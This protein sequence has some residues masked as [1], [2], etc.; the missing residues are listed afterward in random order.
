MPVQNREL[1]PQDGDLHVLGIWSRAQPDQAHQPPQRHP[2]QRPHHHEPDHASP[3]IV[4]GH[5]PSRDVAPFRHPHLPTIC[6][7]C[8]GAG[9]AD[10]STNTH[11]HRSRN[12]DDVLGTHRAH[13][14]VPAGRL[15]ERGVAPSPP[16]S[17][18]PHLGKIAVTASSADTGS[19]AKAPPTPSENLATA[20]RATG[21]TTNA[22][23]GQRHPEPLEWHPSRPRV[24]RKR[25]GRS[26]LTCRTTTATAGQS[27]GRLVQGE[28]VVQPG[29]R[30][31]AHCRLSQGCRP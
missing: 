6:R 14:R 16:R 22:C 7:C 31:A 30:G 11:T 29:S 24:Q 27:P 26:M 19:E 25:A 17:R 5:R 15:S 2:A 23:Y 10:S 28:F 20:E 9:S 21:H 1:V 4:P 8:A 12:P 13:P 18:G 3:G